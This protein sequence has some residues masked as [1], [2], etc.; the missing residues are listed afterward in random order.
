MSSDKREEKAAGSLN[1]NDSDF[2]DLPDYPNYVSEPPFIP[3]WA[4]I[5]LCEEMLPVWNA[6]RLEEVAKHA[7]HETDFYI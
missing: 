4:N 3:V 7:G 1:A 2:L 6:R 5:K